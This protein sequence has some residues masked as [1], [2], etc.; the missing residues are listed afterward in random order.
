MFA[1]GMLICGQKPFH[2]YCRNRLKNCIREPKLLLPYF[3]SRRDRRGKDEIRRIP[4]IMQGRE[5][6]DSGGA[7]SCT[8]SF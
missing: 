1:N 8:L 7:G 4:K 5:W 3:T 6:N 2:S